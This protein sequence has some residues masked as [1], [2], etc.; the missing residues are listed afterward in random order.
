MDMRRAADTAPQHSR[1]TAG[2]RD[3]AGFAR[4]LVERGDT[5]RDVVV[6]G[7]LLG[8]TPADMFEGAA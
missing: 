3:A 6:A 8:F 7:G 5:M 1:Q 2:H 4:P